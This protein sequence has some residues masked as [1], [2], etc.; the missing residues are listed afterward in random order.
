VA[1]YLEDIGGPGTS[2]VSIYLPHPEWPMFSL[3]RSPGWGDRGLHR[4]AYKRDEMA[5]LVNDFTS[6]P[7]IVTCEELLS[8]VPDRSVIP[9]VKM[10]T[11]DR[12]G[13]QTARR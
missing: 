7:C 4:A 9:Q 2:G 10:L 3:A 8:Q 1:F 11:R 6:P 5:R 12:E 13:R